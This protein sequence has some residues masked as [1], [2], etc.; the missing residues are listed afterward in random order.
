MVRPKQRQKRLRRGGKNTQK[1]YTKM[2]VNVPDNH[3]GVVTHLQPHILKCDQVGLSKHYCEQSSGG[4]GKPA[5]L[6][7][8][9]KYDAVKV[10]HSICHQIEKLSNGHRIGKGQF[11]FQS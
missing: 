2:F 3:D 6:F 9:L 11:S 10:L 7:K 5:E 1:N 4:D 8:N